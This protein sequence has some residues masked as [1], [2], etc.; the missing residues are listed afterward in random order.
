MD[1]RARQSLDPRIVVLNRRRLMLWVGGFDVLYACQ[2]F[3][4][5]RQVGPA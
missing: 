3:E 4:H 5:D 2:D 1:R